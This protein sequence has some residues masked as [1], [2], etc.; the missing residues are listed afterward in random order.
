MNLQLPQFDVVI[1]ISRGSF[2]KRGWK[3]T[4]DFVSPSPCPFNY[5]AIPDYIG[6]EGTFLMPLFL[7]RDYPEGKL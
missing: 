2:L 3:G 7:N 4:V 5:G 6:C 1:E